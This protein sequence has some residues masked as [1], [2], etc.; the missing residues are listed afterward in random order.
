MQLAVSGKIRLALECAFHALQCSL[1]F[2]SA[3]TFPDGTGREGQHIYYIV[4][5]LEGS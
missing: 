4:R 1:G 3:V 2:V 5:D